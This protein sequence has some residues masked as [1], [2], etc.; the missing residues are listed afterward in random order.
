MANESSAMAGSDGDGGKRR[1]TAAKQ[2]TAST[3]ARCPEGPDGP[4]WA[5]GVAWQAAVACAGGK[6]VKKRALMTTTN[7]RRPGEVKMSQTTEPVNDDVVDP[8]NDDERRRARR[9]RCQ[10]TEVMSWRRAAAAHASNR[11]PVPARWR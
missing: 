10:V 9:A 4:G 1:Q 8:V 3:N 7:R 5:G 11:E 2:A 6:S